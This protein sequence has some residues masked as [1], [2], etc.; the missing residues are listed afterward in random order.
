MGADAP[1][2]AGRSDFFERVYAVVAEIPP[3]RVTTYGHVA[4][5]LGMKRS[6]RT[7]GWA[8]KAA[9]GTDLP[10]HRVVNRR[11]ALTGR[12]HF[13]T[14]DAME[15]RLRAEGVAFNDD[16]EVVLERHLWVPGGAEP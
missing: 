2:A 5:H 1:S 7:V 14:P 11:G 9:A 10:C 13:E 15:E 3:G 4:E 6:A 8:L 16:G 12:L